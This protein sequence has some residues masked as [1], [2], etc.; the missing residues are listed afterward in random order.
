MMA[1]GILNTLV[2]Y[3]YHTIAEIMMEQRDF[4]ST[5]LTVTVLCYQVSIEI[6]QHFDLMSSNWVDLE[7]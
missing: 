6:I 4:L 5:T 2:P 1:P 7:L 3:L